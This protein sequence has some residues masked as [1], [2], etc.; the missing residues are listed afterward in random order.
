MVGVKENIVSGKT[1]SGR[2]QFVAFRNRT[3][4]KSGG[5][6]VGSTCRLRSP[7]S[8][9]VNQLFRFRN[10]GWQVPPNLG[11]LR[12]TSSLA[13]KECWLLE[14]ILPARHYDWIAHFGRRTSCIA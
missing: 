3:K 2:P 1:I 12:G 14:E 8:K 10:Y 9:K 4:S 5:W 7:S 11:M 13:A 6:I